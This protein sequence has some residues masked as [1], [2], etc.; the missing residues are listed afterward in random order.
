[1]LPCMVTGSSLDEEATACT[2]VTQWLWLYLGF[3]RGLLQ[4]SIVSGSKNFCLLPSRPQGYHIASYEHVHKGQISAVYSTLRTPSPG[5]I[6]D[7]WHTSREQGQ[8]L[9]SVKSWCNHQKK[10]WA[11]RYLWHAALCGKVQHLLNID[12]EKAPSRP[13]P[14]KNSRWMTQTLKG[15]QL[16]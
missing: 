6:L 8:L 16:L 1:M 9:L 5:Q 11:S 10:D 3:H 12:T 13:L 4:Y 14:M 2:A 15:C 7:I